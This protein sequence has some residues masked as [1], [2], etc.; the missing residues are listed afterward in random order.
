MGVFDGNPKVRT[1]GRLSQDA[2]RPSMGA[3]SPPASS[4][5]QALIHGDREL[6]IEGSLKSTT[7]RDRTL[8][9]VQNYRCQVMGDRVLYD[10]ANFT[11]HT[12]AKETRNVFGPTIRNYVGPVSAIFIAPLTETHCSPRNINEPTTWFESVQNALKQY[13][14]DLD[15][16]VASIEFTLSDLYLKGSAFGLTLVGYEDTKFNLKKE[17]AKV[18]INAVSYT[19]MVI[20]NLSVTQLYVVSGMTASSL[21]LASNSYAM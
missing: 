19:Q 7:L 13:N 10:L 20:V 9:T 2:W 4:T 6:T 12:I 16:S 3:L 11:H 1:R 15:A 14:I 17:D 8:V 21:K 5:E 18:V